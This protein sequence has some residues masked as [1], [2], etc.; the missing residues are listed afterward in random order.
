MKT[1]LQ[2]PHIDYAE[3]STMDNSSIRECIRSNRYQGHTAGLAKGYLQTNVA[4][5]PE[6]YVA[7]FL[8][9]CDKNSRSCPLSA[10]SKV[11]DPSIPELGID[12]D[13]RSDVPLYNVYRYGVLE[14]STHNIEHL[15]QDDF[16]T[17][18]LGCSFTFEHVALEAGI[19]LWHIE[20]NKTIPMFRTNIPA[21]AVGPFS[22]NIVVSMRSIPSD[23]VELI[24]ELSQRFPLA[25]GAPIHIGDP[26][27]IGI[28][29][30]DEPD[31]GDSAPVGKNQIPV[32]WACGVTPQ[33]LIENAGIP[34]F[35]SHKPGH[36]L[37]T[38]VEDD[39][40]STFFGESN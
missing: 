25:H 18:A 12:L 2:T 34:L 35:I 26:N 22:G 14:A 27:K 7:D 37:I 5:M 24:S 28:S 30:T 39:A 21:V 4:I 23:Q 40:S 13:I 32:F 20:N 36:M 10:V 38:D 8:K 33:V 16:V 15:W 29:N 6:R 31:W 1:P 17:F 3:L 19:P 11:G 9:L